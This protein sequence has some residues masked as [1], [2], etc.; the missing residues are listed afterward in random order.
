[1]V[2]SRR[3]VEDVRGMRLSFPGRHRRHGR[4]VALGAMKLPD[5]NQATVRLPSGG[6]DSAPSGGTG[7]IGRNGRG[8]TIASDF[9]RLKAKSAFGMGFPKSLPK[10]SIP[11]SSTINQLIFG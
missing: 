11:L 3:L 2:L 1:M 4:Q 7:G 8:R 5:G 10:S 6:R 9:G